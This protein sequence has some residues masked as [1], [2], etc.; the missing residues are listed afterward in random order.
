[1]IFGL[2]EEV[3][4]GATWRTQGDAGSCNERHGATS[5]TTQGIGKKIWRGRGQPRAGHGSGL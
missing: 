2:R 5:R 1:M 3:K 4:A